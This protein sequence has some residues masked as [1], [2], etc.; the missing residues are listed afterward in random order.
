MADKKQNQIKNKKVIL[1][2]TTG[3]KIDGKDPV[4]FFTANQVEEILSNVDERPLP[5]APDY[6]A[7]LCFWRQR[8]LPVID[9]Q[10]QHG[11]QSVTVDSDTRYLVVRAVVPITKGTEI[12]RYVLKVSGQIVTAEIPESC[13][14]VTKDLAGIDTSLTRGIFECGDELMIVP[15][16]ASVYCLM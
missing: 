1:I 4:L 11:L 12:K 9:I 7:G 3:E 2:R 8:I 15:D 13:S 14:S 10:K 6:L 16:L 5:F